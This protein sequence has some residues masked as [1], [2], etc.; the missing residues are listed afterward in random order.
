MRHFSKRS[1]ALVD[2]GRRDLDE[3]IEAEG[4][5]PEGGDNG[6]VEHG[7]SDGVCVGFA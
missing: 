1:N 7:F 2:V 3:L 6:S 5:N 4:F